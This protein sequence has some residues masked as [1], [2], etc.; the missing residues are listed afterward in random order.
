MQHT[1]Q[2]DH[3]DPP[4]LLHAKLVVP[5]IVPEALCRQQLQDQLWNLTDL[6]VTVITGPAGCGK[7]QLVA[8]WLAEDGDPVAWLTLDRDDRQQPNRMWRHLIGALRAAGVILP[9]GLLERW[10][11]LAPDHD[12]VMEVAA[13]LAEW[14]RSLLLVLDNATWLDE[15]QLAEVDYLVRHVGC[16]RLLLIGRCRPRFPLHRYR[17]ADQLSEV[18]A[19]ELRL[20]AEETRALFALHD[21]ELSDEEL[22]D[23]IR[24]TGGWITGVRLCAQAMRHDPGGPVPDLAAHEHIVEYLT[25]EVLH[26][27]TAPQQELLHGVALLDTFTDDLVAAAAGEPS[28]THLLERLVEAGA[29]IETVDADRRMHRVHPLLR[30]LLDARLAAR[31]H[32]ARALRLRLARWLAAIGDVAGAVAQ[33]AAAGAWDDAARILVADHGV[34]ALVVDGRRG[35]FA[36]LLGD[37]PAAPSTAEG[38]VVAA[39]LAITRGD[40]DGA[41]RLM[42]GRPVEPAPGTPLALAVSTCVLHQ[43]LAFFAG[44]VERLAAATGAGVHLLELAGERLRDRPELRVYVQ[45]GAAT[46]LLCTGRLAEA[47][48]AF[49]DAALAA[50]G[51]RCAEL[52]AY[53]MQHLALTEA[54]RGRLRTAHHA[55]QRAIALASV[56]CRRHHVADA[57]LAWVATEWYDIDAAWRHLRAAESGLGASARTPQAGAFA[58]VLALVRARLLRARGELPAALSAVR[59]AGGTGQSRVWIR[60]QAALTELRL[61]LAMGRD[62]EVRDGLA[63]LDP[64]APDVVLVG[65]EAL[66]A[67]SEPDRAIERADLVLRDVDLPQDV[68]AEAWLLLA[69]GVARQGEQWRA[70]EAL[71]TAVELMAEEGAVR[72][73]Y[74]AD[75]SVRRLLR[76]Q[77]LALPAMDGATA[78]RGR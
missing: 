71:R 1:D 4:A 15:E 16:L 28:P 73:A 47:A 31:P 59:Q 7:T 3:G 33:T 68:A 49:T 5:E 52:L 17:L 72:V 24:Q 78:D 51:P 54:L 19:D 21:V 45:A 38:A 20:D 74:E 13:A 58:T 36:E 30:P 61:L 39:A 18:T 44:D 62:Q 43:A 50:E 11:E 40:R 70:V 66:L 8:A 25:G 37:A 76:Q 48:Q 77:D 35:P 14:N 26:E 57:A 69:A 65:G 34:C 41:E 22:A 46:V 67:A 2:H 63:G 6:P 27:L 75:V 23:V 9:A 42:A 32:D 10:A 60:H 12:C 56:D 29:L 64:G 53:C 55:A